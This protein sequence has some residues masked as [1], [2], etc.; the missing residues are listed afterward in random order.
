M[1]NNMSNSYTVVQ[2]ILLLFNSRVLMKFVADLDIIRPTS[3]I[4]CFVGEFFQ[5]VN[6]NMENGRS[7]VAGAI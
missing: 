4:C 3:N 6:L 2:G 1:A 5:H 7:I